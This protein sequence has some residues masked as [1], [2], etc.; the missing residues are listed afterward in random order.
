MRTLGL[1]RPGFP[2]P[3]PTET[4]N[5]SKGSN[6]Q[7]SV[8]WPEA[9][10]SGREEASFPWGLETRIRHIQ[11]QGW[12]RWAV[13]LGDQED[14]KEVHTRDLVKKADSGRT[15]GLCFCLGGCSQKFG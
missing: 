12:S 15:K 11:A 5:K 7:I 10:R 2:G 4:F 9:Q 8:M 14:S 6:C 13:W 1:V 3:W